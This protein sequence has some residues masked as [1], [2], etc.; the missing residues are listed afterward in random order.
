MRAFKSEISLILQNKKLLCLLI[1]SDLI[2]F[3]ESDLLNLF[4]DRLL[5]ADYGLQYP[6][7]TWFIFR[8]V[9]NLEKGLDEQPKRGVTDATDRRGELV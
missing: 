2:I 5:K 6:Y 4:T 9:K 7:R 8:S 3:T 1:V